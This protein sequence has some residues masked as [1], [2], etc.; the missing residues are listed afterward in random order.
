M[1]RR[2]LP[3][4]ENIFTLDIT[5]GQTAYL[6]SYFSCQMLGNQPRVSCD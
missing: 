6:S 4:A 2:S 3:Q 1:R 5:R